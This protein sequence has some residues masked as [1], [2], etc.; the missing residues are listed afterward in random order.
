MILKYKSW[1]RLFLIK[2]MNKKPIGIEALLI[3][4]RIRR[5]TT[6]T[7][8]TLF[9][10]N[11]MCNRPTRLSHNDGTNILSNSTLNFLF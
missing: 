2:E 5:N 3:L 4:T 9:K 11:K 1:L 8:M 7:Y 10:I 6:M